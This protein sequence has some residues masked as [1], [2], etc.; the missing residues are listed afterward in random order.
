LVAVA[1]VEHAMAVAV[2]A[3]VLSKPM[4]MSFPLQVQLTL[5][6]AL[7]DLRRLVIQAHQEDLLT[8]GHPQE[9]SLQLVEDVAKMD[10]LMQVEDLAVALVGIN[11]LVQQLSVP[12]LVFQMGQH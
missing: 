1:V 3:A 8:L 11:L 5:Q 7:E 4:D 10:L 6:L 2:V 12:K 9:V